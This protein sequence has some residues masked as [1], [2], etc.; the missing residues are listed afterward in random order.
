[1]LELYPNYYSKF[2]CTADQC[3][4]T[5]C[6]EWK[7]AVDDDTYRNWFTIQPPTDVTPQ[8]ATLSAYTTYQEE[9][10]V[11][12]LNKQKKCPFLK[13]K[14][15]ADWFSHM[16]M[17]SCRIHVLHFHGNFIPFPIT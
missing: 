1:M 4:I 15:F 10:R 17:P 3:P 13:E 7:I 12:R 8:K 11:I 14:D 9:A 6:Q 5:C 2:T 16:E